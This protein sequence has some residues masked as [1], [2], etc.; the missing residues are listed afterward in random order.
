[1]SRFALA[2]L[3]LISLAVSQSVLAAEVTVSQL[4]SDPLAFDDRHVTVSGTAQSLE[5]ESSHGHAYETFQL[6]EQ[7]CVRVFTLGHPQITEGKQITVKGKFEADTAFGP[8]VL[9]DEIITDNGSL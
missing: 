2:M 4:L 8:F 6:C 5:P 7:S 9:H 1:M 3:L